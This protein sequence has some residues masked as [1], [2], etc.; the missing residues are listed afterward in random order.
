MS[1]YDIAEIMRRLPHRYPILMVDRIIECDDMTHIVGIKNVSANEPFFQG[2]FPGE[3]VMPGV[4]Q[5]EAM[6]Q[7][8]GFL[9]LRRLNGLGMMAYFMTIDKAKFRSIVR[10]GDQLRIEV[11][12]TSLRSKV[13]RFRARVLVDGAVASEAELMCMVSDRKAGAEA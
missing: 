6:A 1:T 7:T 3:P 2:H 11:E 9:L 12:I 8:G 10:P 4:L 5:L 13:A